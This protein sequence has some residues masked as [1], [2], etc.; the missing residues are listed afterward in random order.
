LLTIGTNSIGTL[1]VTGC[2][3]V[4]S[5]NGILVNNHS[6]SQLNISGNA[7]TGNEIGLQI[8][9]AAAISKGTISNNTFNANEDNNLVINTFG[10]NILSV[11]GNTFTGIISPTLGY[12]ATI[13]AGAGSLCLD[14]AQNTAYPVNLGGGIN[15][16]SLINTATFDLTPDSTQANNIG[17]ITESG[18]SFGS[19]TQ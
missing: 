2:N 13:T 16:Y 5:T 19:C 12:A 9:P 18:P 7:F 15:P 3:F 6:V 14:F 8:I 10:S 11:K 1:A 17:T 4:G